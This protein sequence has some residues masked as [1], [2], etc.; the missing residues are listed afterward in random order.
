MVNKPKAIGTTCES[1]VVKLARLSGFPHA[2][3]V[4]LHGATDL[5]DVRLTPGLTA[6]VIVEVKGGKAAE[7]ASD[8]QIWEWLVETQREA[9]AAGADVGMLVTKRAG[10][11][12]A[13]A[14]HWWAH[15]TLGTMPRLGDF[16]Y[17]EL[18]SYAPVRMVLRDALTLLRTVGYGEPLAE[19]EDV[20]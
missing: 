16:Y 13:R 7:T 6:G 10:Y 12:A 2:E 9:L 14:E 20:A 5:G 11:A 15:W 19:L 17:A 1:A 18:V 8:G 4:P 3:R